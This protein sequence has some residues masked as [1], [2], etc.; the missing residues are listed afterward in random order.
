MVCAKTAPLDLLA[1]QKATAPEPAAA[2]RRGWA[3]GGGL[4]QDAGSQGEAG[5]EGSQ[6]E[7]SGEG[8]T[9]GGGAEGMGERQA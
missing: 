8:E 7:R 1:Q 9:E 3:R 6:Q 5:G 4:G 2:D